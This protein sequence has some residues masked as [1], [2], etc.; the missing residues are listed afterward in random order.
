MIA[1]APVVADARVPVDNQ[2]VDSKLVQARGDRQTAL[3]AADDD[4]G[5]IVVGIAARPSE[6]VGPV[7]GAK[8]AY[9]V[10][11]LGRAAFQFFFMTL[12]FF[13]RGDNRPRAQPRQGVGNETD[14]ARAGAEGGFEF[15]QAL[16]RFSAGA[17][18]ASRRR[19]VRG[20]REFPPLRAR[21]PRAR[22]RFGGPRP[23]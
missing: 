8:I 16:D 2:R 15:E 6:A 4:H 9:A 21:E 18:D 3:S 5:G 20:E 22:R 17:R 23:G 14:D 1:R 19:P 12:E 10:S 13:E 7:L 11:S